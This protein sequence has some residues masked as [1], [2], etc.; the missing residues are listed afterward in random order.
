MSIQ[1]CENCDTHID[2]D[3]DVD[4]FGECNKMKHIEETVVQKF[5][6]ELGIL[7]N[8]LGIDDEEDV[9]GDI[10]G[11]VE[12]KLTGNTKYKDKEKE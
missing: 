11:L 8:H 3:F 1:Y 2:T 4:H 9:Y 12:L 10:L 5:L 6:V 7:L